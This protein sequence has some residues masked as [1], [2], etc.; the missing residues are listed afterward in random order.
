MPSSQANMT[1]Y[2]RNLIIMMEC[3]NEPWDIKD[4]SSR[5]VYMNKAAYL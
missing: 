4:L 2:I 5:H 1:D 3:L